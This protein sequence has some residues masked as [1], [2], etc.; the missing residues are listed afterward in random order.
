MFKEYLLFL[1]NICSQ[2]RGRD[3]FNGRQ[4][5]KKGPQ[6]SKEGK[7]GIWRSKKFKFLTYI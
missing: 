3:P 5:P 4:I 1:L 7:I 6:I 2:I